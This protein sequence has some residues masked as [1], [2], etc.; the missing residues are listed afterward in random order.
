MADDDLIRRTAD[1]L[2]IRNV[3]AK[4]AIHADDGNSAAFISCLAEDIHWQ[5][6]A[7]PERPP[8]IGRTAFEAVT[9][10]TG[11]SMGPGSGSIH[12]V[13]TSVITLNGDT[14]TVKSYLMYFPNILAKPEPSCRIY[15]DTY[16]RTPG[17]WKLSVRY[18]DPI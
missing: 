8:I 1:E 7:N 3:I 14:A 6:R 10:M 15:N 2:E 4:L 5:N 18:I 11:A 13:P 16:V 17:G 9:K 12:T